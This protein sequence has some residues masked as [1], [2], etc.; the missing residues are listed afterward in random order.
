MAGFTY[1][2]LKQAV[3]EYVENTE[4][5]FVGQLDTFIRVAEDRILKNVP[6]EVFRKN[7]TA[8]LIV[9]DKYLAKPT[10]WLHSLSMS[11]V[12]TSGHSFLLNKDVNFIQDFWPTPTSTG[13]PK[14]YADYDLTSFIIA[15]TPASADTVELHYFY[16]PQSIVDATG[17]TTWLGTNASQTMLYG[18][19]VEAY[20][21]M[22]GEADLIQLY[23]SRF[24]NSLKALQALGVKNEPTDVYRSGTA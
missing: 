15:P 24:M 17:G 21:F 4:S 13:V 11:V 9:G 2:T 23:E 3:Q 22:K 8:T 16:R 1:T 12:G 7:T 10:D 14:Y 18:A 20:I 6:L 5:T 19:L